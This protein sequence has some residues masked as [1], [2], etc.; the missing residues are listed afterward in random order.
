MTPPSS[1][2]FSCQAS[3]VA[4]GELISRFLK[5]QP[6]EILNCGV[7]VAVASTVLV[8]SF[9]SRKKPVLTA[10]LVVGVMVLSGVS[11]EVAAGPV[12]SSV[13][14]IELPEVR[15]FQELKAAETE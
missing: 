12:Q 15:R 3:L 14:M 7:T 4:V 9:W 5:R 6:P 13:V 1:M 11:I 8:M 10:L 2:P